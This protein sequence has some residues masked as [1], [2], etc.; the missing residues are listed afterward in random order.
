MFSKILAFFWKDIKE[1]AS[2]KLNFVFGLVG[3][4]FWLFILFYIGKM[5]MYKNIPA[6]AS[7]GG[8]Y[9]SFALVGVAFAGYFAALSNAFETCL[10]IEQ[11]SGRLEAILT[12][13][14][15]ISTLLAIGAIP[16]FLR[17]LLRVAVYFCIGVL[18]FKIELGN[19]NFISVSLVLLFTAATAGALGLASAGYM[20][21]FKKTWPFEIILGT[22]MTFLSGTYFP[23][24]LFPS[25]VQRIAHLLPLT[26]ILNAMRQAIFLGKGIRELSSEITILALFALVLIPLSIIFFRICFRK[27]KMD[28]SLVFI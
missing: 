19:V 4:C 12:T 22:G 3:I 18:V 15:G 8:D 10:M 28:G 20:L 11:E 16:E 9:F 2:Y 5:I 26:H 23:V 21:A 1:R 13:K 7:L 14:T 6:L 24:A 17:A 25:W 27:A